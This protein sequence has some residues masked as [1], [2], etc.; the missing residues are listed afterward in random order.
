MVGGIAQAAA[1][2]GA[3]RGNSSSEPRWHQMAH[4]HEDVDSWNEESPSDASNFSDAEHDEINNKRRKMH[5]QIGMMNKANIPTW[6]IERSLA[7]LQQNEE[8][9]S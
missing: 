1:R 8:N 4:M 2:A 5:A 9:A 7:T 3:I 6:M